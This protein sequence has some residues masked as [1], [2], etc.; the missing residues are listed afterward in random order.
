MSS[1]AVH[2]ALVG[3][4]GH[5]EGEDA[6]RFPHYVFENVFFRNAVAPRVDGEGEQARKRSRVEEP[7]APPLP[8][9]CVSFEWFHFSVA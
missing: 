6:N 9:L 8:R 2:I 4:H 1:K 5:G 3:I 7:R